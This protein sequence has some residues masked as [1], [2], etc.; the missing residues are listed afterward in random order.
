M[1]WYIVLRSAWPWLAKL[2]LARLAKAARVT[3]KGTGDI[4]SLLL[5]MRIFGNC[6][7]TTW[8]QHCMG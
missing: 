6:L 8:P 7:V 5:V 3:V 4:L 1:P 2:C